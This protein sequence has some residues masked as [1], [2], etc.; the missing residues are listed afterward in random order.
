MLFRP[1]RH[2]TFANFESR[3]GNRLART[4]GI[5]YADACGVTPE[6]SVLLLAGRPGAGKTHL[7]H[8]AVN[9][10]KGNENIRRSSIL[11]SHRLLEELVT[12][13]SYDDL[14]QLLDR[15]CEDDLLA[16]DDIDDLFAH[17]DWANVVLELLQARKA[18]RKRSLLTLSLTKA[19]EIVGPLTD[20][21]NQRRAYAL[22]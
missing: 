12:A 16:I 13:E 5:V 4:M 8:A 2:Y 7:L 22:I 17:R 1:N 19:P 21:L 9:R 14:P 18:Q 11:S 10:A 6:C 15:W 3:P 20:F